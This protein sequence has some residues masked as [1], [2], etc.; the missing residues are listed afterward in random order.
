MNRS[1]FTVPATFCMAAAIVTAQTPAERPAGNP[2]AGQEPAAQQPT[3]PRPADK[4]A[5]AAQKVTYTGCIKPGTTMGTRTL[6]S[7]EVAAKT[8]VPAPGSS[9]P[10]TVGTS[11]SA[12]TTLDLSSAATVN[13]K[14]H[15]NHKVEVVGTLSPAKTG[16]GAAASSS[17][18]AGAAHQGAA[19]HQQFTVES[20]K[21]VSTTCP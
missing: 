16:A 8:G 13:L 7:A 17:S 6:E 21:M 3:T 19:A 20:V 12:K 5:M 1:L 11:G 2:T 4:S 18:A 10:G 14:A 9:A 15:V